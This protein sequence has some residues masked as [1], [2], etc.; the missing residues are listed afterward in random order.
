MNDLDR[1]APRGQAGPRR[2]RDHRHRNRGDQ[3]QDQPRAGLHAA[4]QHREA[5]H[6]AGV[7]L[8]QRAGRQRSK[9]AGSGR[10]YRRRRPPAARRS[11][12]AAASP[13]GPRRPRATGAAVAPAPPRRAAAL[14]Q[15]PVLRATWPARAPDACRRPAPRIVRLRHLHR[16]HCLGTGLPGTGQRRGADP[17][18]Q[19]QCGEKSHRGHQEWQHPVGNRPA[20]ARARRTPP[21]AATVRLGAPPSVAR[22]F[23]SHASGS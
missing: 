8:G 11:P 12:P 21:A 9:A 16:Q 2:D 7:L 17:A 6:P 23:L 15:R 19:C 13:A 5:A 3:Q 18:A 20:Q 1:L 10:R 14:R 4:C 22:S